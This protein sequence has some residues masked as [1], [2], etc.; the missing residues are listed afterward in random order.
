VHPR[1]KPKKIILQEENLKEIFYRR[2]K[3]NS[4]TLQGGKNMFT[5]HKIILVFLSLQ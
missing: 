3:Q 2:V 5:L 4:P 1:G